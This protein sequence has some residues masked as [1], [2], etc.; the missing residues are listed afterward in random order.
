MDHKLT[1]FM[2]RNEEE[3]NIHLEIFLKMCYAFAVAMRW[4]E[5]HGW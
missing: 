5:N 4:R 1:I 2:N 3:K